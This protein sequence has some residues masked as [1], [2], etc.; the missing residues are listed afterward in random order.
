MNTFEYLILAG[1]VVI[2]VLGVFAS[3]LWLKVYRQQKLH[4]QQ[5]SDQAVASDVAAEAQRQSVNKSIQL[6]ALALNKNEL[7][8]T[9]QDR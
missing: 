5:L 1:A 3:Y 6:L 4:H 8:P 7:S 9:L 2:V